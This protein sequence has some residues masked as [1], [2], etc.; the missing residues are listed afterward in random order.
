VAKPYGPG[1]HLD[2]L[3]VAGNT[4][5]A[6]NGDVSRIERVDSSFATLD[7][8]AMR[9]VVFENNTF[10]GVTQKTLNPVALGFT[11]NSAQTTW[12]CDFAG[13]LPFGGRAKVVESI[14]AEGA[15]TTSGSTAVTSMP[16]VTLE[17]GSG[18]SV[19]QLTWSTAAKGRVRVKARMDL[20]S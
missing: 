8:S 6:F 12:N 14:V 11:Q 10:Y 5:Q 13:W 1:G 3:I 9:N 18:G 7:L 20:Q 17:Q 2:G 16:Y 15:I 19:A 4:F